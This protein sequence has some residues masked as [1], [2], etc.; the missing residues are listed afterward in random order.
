MVYMRLSAVRMR[1]VKSNDHGKLICLQEDLR[2]D[3]LLY[4]THVN[5]EQRSEHAL[6]GKTCV[7][8]V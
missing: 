7:H 2:Y 6:S 1:S 5:I 4:F 3:K 8:Y